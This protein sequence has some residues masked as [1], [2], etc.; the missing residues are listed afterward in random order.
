MRGAVTARLSNPRTLRRRSRRSRADKNI[1]NLS[2]QKS[3]GKYILDYIY[4]DATIY[5]KRKHIYDLLII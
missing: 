4:K 3:R 2:F 5:L 1:Y